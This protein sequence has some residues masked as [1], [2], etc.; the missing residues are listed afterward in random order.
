M[1]KILLMLLALLTVMVGNAAGR[2]INIMNLPPF[3]RAVIIIKKY[4]TLHRPKDY[5]YV[6]YGHR[7]LP[8]EPYRRGMQLTEKQAD[9]LLRKDLRK[10]VS[11]Y[12]AY[13]KDALLLG[14]L[15]Y[16]C[17]PGVVNKSTVLKKLKSGNRD[18]FKSYTAH[19]R[20]KGKFHAQLHQRR[21]IEVT[22][23]FDN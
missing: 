18:I 19:C 15:A 20:Y 13:G 17:G 16:N 1:K 7:V 3:E 9:A 22:V 4:E 10:F 8:G 2:K 14:V 11:L 12:K 6:G 23:L 5:P 21:I